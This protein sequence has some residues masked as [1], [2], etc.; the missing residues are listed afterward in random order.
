MNI[1]VVVLTLTGCAEKKNKKSLLEWIRDVVNDF[2]YSADVSN[3][4]KEFMVIL[5][6]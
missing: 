3:P 4:L 1:F 6:P 5:C 2:W